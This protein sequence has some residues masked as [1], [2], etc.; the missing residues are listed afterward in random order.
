MTYPDNRSEEYAINEH[1]SRPVASPEPLNHCLRPLEILDLPSIPE[2]KILVLPAYPLFDINKL[3]MI[4]DI[5]D[6][7][8]QLIEVRIILFIYAL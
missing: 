6:F 7:F 8:H 2:V 5:V 3:R 1:L 4:G